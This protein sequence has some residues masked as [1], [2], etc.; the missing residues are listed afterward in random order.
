MELFLMKLS[1]SIFATYLVVNSELLKKRSKNVIP[2]NIVGS[3][4]ALFALS[5]MLYA[6]N[7]PFISFPQREERQKK[8]LMDYRK[9]LIKVNS[10]RINKKNPK[11][12]LGLPNPIPNVHFY[13]FVITLVKMS[14]DKDISLQHRKLFNPLKCKRVKSIWQHHRLQ[15]IFLTELLLCQIVRFTTIVFVQ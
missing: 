9:A 3:M 1:R 5:T 12:N 13:L 8:L 14:R 2:W 10:N 11:M 7:V 6:L 15:H 4:M